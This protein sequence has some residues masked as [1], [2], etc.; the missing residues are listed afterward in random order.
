MPTSYWAD[1]PD[2]WQGQG[3]LFDSVSD[4]YDACRP[5]YPEDLIETIIATT[6]LRPGARV[7]EIGSGTGKA[8]APFARRGFSVLCVEPGQN[9]TAVAAAKFAG[10][11]HVEFVASRFEDWPERPGAFDL[12]MSA[13][14]FHWIP[15]QVGYA[16]A[17][18]T[19]QK[20]G[21]LALFW[22]MYPDPQGGVFDDL[23]QAYRDRAPELVVELVSREELSK[24]REAE[25]AE[26]GCF[27]PVRV[28]QFPWSVRYDTRQYLGLLN[29][30]S[31]HLNLPEATRQNL[32]QGIA[33]VIDGHGGGIDRPYVAVLYLAKKA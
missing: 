12:V 21:Y 5:G 7:L 32:F 10:W 2:N 31:D 30:Y 20:N 27:G 29:T 16:K 9:L 8:T 14:A 33:E 18:R 25:I 13:Q 4:L 17:A 26:S 24:Q 23:E 19:L 11:P 22:N 1:K 3:C 15:K 6:N 28:F